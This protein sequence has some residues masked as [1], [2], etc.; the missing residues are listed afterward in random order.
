[1]K[2][3]KSFVAFLESMCT[4]EKRISKQSGEECK[5]KGGRAEKSR[6]VIQTQKVISVKE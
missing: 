3:L 2:V 1:M 6:N 4:H 5:E